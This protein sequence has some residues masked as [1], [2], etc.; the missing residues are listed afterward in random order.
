LQT[1][2]PEKKKTL[3]GAEARL[4]ELAESNDAG[5]SISGWILDDA[6]AHLKD[7]GLAT[8]TTRGASGPASLGGLPLAE[9]IWQARNQHQHFNEGRPFDSPTID[10]LRTM[11]T[12]APTAFGVTSPPSDDTS[13]A[14]LFK[15]QS[16]AK[17]VLVSLGW[18]SA[19]AVCAALKTLV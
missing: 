9:V 13:L 3:E 16:M 14:V 10:A 5:R 12:A 2:Y 4:T 1:G 19:F 11:V 17:E 8:A 18:T 15:S 7:L 6:H